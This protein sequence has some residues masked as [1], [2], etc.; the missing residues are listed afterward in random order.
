MVEPKQK[1]TLFWCL[2]IILN[3][4]QEY[5]ILNRNYIMCEMEWKQ[6]LS[7][8]IS[9]NQALIK[10]SN[11]KMTKAAVQEVLS[12]LLTNVQKTNI[13]CLIAITVY[14]NINIILMAH[15][16]KTRMEYLS[17]NNSNK[18]YL[19]IKNEN[20]KYSLQYDCLTESE[21][22]DIRNNTLLIENE[23]KVMKS[24][25][26]YKVDDLINIAKLLEIYNHN[27]KYKKN[28]LYALICENITSF[29]I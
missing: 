24:I 5:E 11:H 1:D 4:I 13:G 16:K 19:I 20:N 26:S 9:K 21:I 22:I 29:S 18:T 12:D 2:Y 27:E 25:G 6:K 8:E 28:E 10:N 7:G 15:T 23:N 14:R 17:G 3:G